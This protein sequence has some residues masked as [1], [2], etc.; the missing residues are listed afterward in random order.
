MDG[1]STLYLYLISLS[2]GSTKLHCCAVTRPRRA[3]T[4]RSSGRPPSRAATGTG[5]GELGVQGRVLSAGHGAGP[6]PQRPPWQHS[7]PRKARTKAIGTAAS[8][9]NAPGNADFWP[10][11]CFISIFGTK[12]KLP[13]CCLFYNPFPADMRITAKSYN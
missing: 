9:Q 8:A 13:V 6:L 7:R 1:G 11:A 5:G 10:P 2:F 12:K 4:S 3:V